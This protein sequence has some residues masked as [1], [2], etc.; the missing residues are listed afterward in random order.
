MSRYKY[1]GVEA[2]P[3]QLP[4]YLNKKVVVMLNYDSKIPQRGKVIRADAGPPNETVIQLDDKRI[5]LGSECTF[6][7]AIEADG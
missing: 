4:E 1:V 5:V 3:K 2:Y 7:L 6:K